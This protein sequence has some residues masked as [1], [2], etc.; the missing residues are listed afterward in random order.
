MS[1]LLL[2]II[3]LAFIS[4]GL[5]DSVLGAAWPVMYTELGAPL[6]HAGLIAM[7]ISLG[8]VVSSLLSDRLTRRFGSG[9]VTAVSVALTA[10][11]LFGFS[12]SRSFWQLCL[13]AVPYGLGAGGVDACLNN[14]VALHYAS[15]H[16]SWLHCM[17]GIGAATGPV[18]MGRAI[19]GGLG[20]PMGYRMIS[21]LQVGLT[22][23][24]FVSLPI[25]QKRP[26]ADG[27]KSA[28][29]LSLH[30][31]LRIPGVKEVLICFFCYCAIEQTAGLWAASYLVLANGVTEELA[32]T[33]AALFFAGITVG[34]ALNG[35]LTFRFDDK[36]LIRLGCAVILLGVVCIPFG[37]AA[38]MAG[39][40]LT[41]LGCAPVYP[42]VIHSTPAHFGAERSQAIIGVQMA[43][44]YIGTCT[45]PPL[46]GLVAR[47]ISVR[48][49]PLDL[50][51]LL[52]LMALMHERLLKKTAQS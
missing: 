28:N 12:C 18:I 27:E 34:R 39:F 22:A 15:R 19:T 16:M 46:F 36:T 1:H 41:G 9:L 51:L 49:L 38:S 20:W 13:I 17:W 24:L 35:F 32:A 48:L 50:L 8:T 25:W 4:L 37:G 7:I 2:A 23:V 26:D 11:A 44:A 21:W 52:G 14:Y 47:H 6:S 3:Y 33:L 31:I 30:E 29:A 10:A 42:C 5:P 40:V 45:M 43:A